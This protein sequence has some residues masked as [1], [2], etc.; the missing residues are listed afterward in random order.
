MSGRK[1]LC[2]VTACAAM[3]TVAGC[4]NEGPVLVDVRGTVTFNG[5]PAPAEIMFEPEYTPGKGGG[6]ASTA[7]TAADGSYRLAFTAD[8]YGAVPGKHRVLIR[9]LNSTKPGAAK[10]FEEASGAVKSCELERTVSAGHS[11]FH[12]PLR[13]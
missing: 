2:R 3:L 10:T 1:V 6:R 7:R 12:F 5:Q 13:W 8:R 4:S 9:V 11:T